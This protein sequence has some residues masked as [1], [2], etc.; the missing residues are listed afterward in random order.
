M[1]VRREG[2]EGAA[3]S[4][5]VGRV[6]LGAGTVQGAGQEDSDTRGRCWFTKALADG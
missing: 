1:R 5:V 6:A 2:A 4:M 3:M